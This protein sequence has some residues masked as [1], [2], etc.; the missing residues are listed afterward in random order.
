MN[1]KVLK[2][3]AFAA[4]LGAAATAGLAVAQPRTHPRPARKSPVTARRHRLPVPRT[5]S[6]DASAWIP[7]GLRTAI[8]VHRGHG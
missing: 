3:A 4:A 2:S 5:G 1:V 6:P 7:C 8:S